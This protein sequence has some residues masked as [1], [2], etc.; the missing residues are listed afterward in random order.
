VYSNQN[1]DIEKPS[2]NLK[3]GRYFGTGS[4]SEIAFDNDL[5]VAPSDSSKSCNLGMEFKEGHV[6]MLS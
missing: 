4:N 3:S 5:L 6:G 2:E 1:F